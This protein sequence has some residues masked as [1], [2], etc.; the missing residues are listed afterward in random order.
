MFKSISRLGAAFV[1]AIAL[2]LPAAAS[3][4]SIDYSDLWG[5][6]QPVPTEQGWGLNLI[7]QGDVIFA[8]WFVYAQN[9]TPTWFSATLNPTSG[10]TTWSGQVVFVPSASY[11]G[12]ALGGTPPMN[13]VGNATITFSNVNAGTLSWSA[14]GVTVNKQI[15]R[16]SLRAPNLAGKYLGGMVATCSSGAGLLIF[17]TLNVSQSGNSLTMTV[18]FFDSQSRQTRCTYNGTL[19]TLGRSGS[20]SG[21]YSCAITATGQGT[22]AGTFTL[23]NLESGING[24]SSN[25]SGSDQFCSSQ[26]GRFGGVKDVQ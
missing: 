3:T 24:F 25:Y 14:N 15:S 13:V 8:T 22:N 12:G 11:Y 1:S 4:F 9:G 17:D 5:G 23:S 21:N 18:D 10:S 2:S 19:T 26:S 16:F 7:Q 6:G 20:V